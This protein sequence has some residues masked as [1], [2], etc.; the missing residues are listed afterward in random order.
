MSRVQVWGGELSALFSVQ[1]RR[2]LWQEELGPSMTVEAVPKA[3]ARAAQI[4]E[5]E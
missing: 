5:G 1:T 3:D 4:E 2:P